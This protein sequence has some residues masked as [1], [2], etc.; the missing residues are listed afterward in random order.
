MTLPSLHRMTEVAIVLLLVIVIRTLGEIIRLH[1]IFED[2]LTSA[3]AGPF[4]I[5]ALGAAVAALA[6]AIL[7]F[8]ERD[9]AGLVVTVCAIAG[10]LV[11]KAV[12]AG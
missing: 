11:Y 1:Y 8:L 6:V 3:Q 5:G 7:H 4:V 2:H 10:L 9:R 12:A